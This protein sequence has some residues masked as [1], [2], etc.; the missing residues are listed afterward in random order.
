MKS[1]FFLL[2]L[3]LSIISSCDKGKVYEKF[4]KDFT[5]NRWPSATV[6]SYDFNITDPSKNYELLLRFS[7]VYNYQLKTIPIQLEIENPDKSIDL[8]VFNV[9][10]VD[11][12]GKDVGDCSGDYCDVDQV[13]FSDQKLQ[14]GKYKIKISQ[15]FKG[16][17][18]P[19]V[20]GVGIKITAVN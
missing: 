6:K 14:A 13:V 19:N 4:D 15:L 18:L 16:T 8:K 12:A 17:Y 10:I 3:M 20:L 7:H 1:R 2:L 11:K 5:D 9:E